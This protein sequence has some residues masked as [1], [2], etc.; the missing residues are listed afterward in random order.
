MIVFILSNRSTIMDRYNNAQKINKYSKKKKMRLY[1]HE[2]KFP[3]Y[4]VQSHFLLF[5]EISNPFSSAF[6]CSLISASHVKLYQL[7]AENNYSIRN[8]AL[9]LYDLTERKEILHSN[10]YFNLEGCEIISRK[11][12]ISILCHCTQTNSNHY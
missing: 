8:Q 11:F 6:E 3:I 9:K 10:G 2:I 7:M 12:V 5:S 1:F 4:E